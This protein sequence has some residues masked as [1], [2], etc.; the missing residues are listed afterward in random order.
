MGLF[1]EGTGWVSAC[2]GVGGRSG[3]CPL[4]PLPKVNSSE[5]HST[6]WHCPFKPLCLFVLL[7]QRDKENC[8]CKHSEEKQC[9]SLSCTSDKVLSVKPELS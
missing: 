5:L 3:R 8:F 6:D 1:W 4:C 9:V 2:S 7:G